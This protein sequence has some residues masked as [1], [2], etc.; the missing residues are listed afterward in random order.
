[1]SCRSLCR[2]KSVCSIAQRVTD[3]RYGHSHQFRS[4][5]RAFIQKSKTVYSCGFLPRAPYVDEAHPMGGRTS[6]KLC[7]IPFPN[8]SRSG[9]FRAYQNRFDWQEGKQADLGTRCSCPLNNSLFG[10]NG[11][12]SRQSQELRVAPTYTA[13]RLYDSMSSN[14]FDKA[15]IFRGHLQSPDS[16]VTIAVPRCSRFKGPARAGIQADSAFRALVDC[17]CPM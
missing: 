13:S 5:M 14:I 10:N 9:A 16:S 8:H 4:P 11:G 17:N 7:Q 2:D 12:S 3:L 6:V 1:M 15:W